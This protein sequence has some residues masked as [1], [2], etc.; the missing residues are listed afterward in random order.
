[1]SEDLP[2]IP[3]QLPR[4]VLSM[5]ADGQA[6][7][8]E[9]AQCLEL[10]GSNPD[11]RA[12]WHVYQVIGD[13]MRSDELAA[14]AA[15]DEAFLQGLRRRLAQEPARLAPSAPRPLSAPRPA[16]LAPVAMAAGV[17]AVALTLTAL[18]PAAGLSPQPAVTLA[19]QRVPASAAVVV[20]NTPQ[21]HVVSG[22]LIRDARLDRY[23]AAHRQVSSGSTLQMPGAVVRSVDTIVLDSK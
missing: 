21:V 9:Q 1:M 13:V 17:G 14:G 6:D 19:A 20:S 12:Q 5:L 4:Q 3:G 2:N 8:T 23:L 15:D 10:W 18:W 11:V 16:W 7:A 22:Q